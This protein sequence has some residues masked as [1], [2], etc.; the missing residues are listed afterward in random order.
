MLVNVASK[1]FCGVILE[2]IKTALDAKLREVQAGF[3]ANRGC[4]DQ[5]AILDCWGT[6][7]IEWQ[8]ILH[9][10]FIDFKMTFKSISRE[11][12][13]RLLRHYGMPVQVSSYHHLGSS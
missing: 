2:R 5:I 4:A 10:N 11:V 13:W 7:Q 9:F 1:V 6:E 12:L 8:S 3:R